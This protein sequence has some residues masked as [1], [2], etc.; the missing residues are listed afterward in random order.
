MK[1]Q[2]AVR[3]DS[4]VYHLIL[5]GWQCPSINR[6]F[7]SIT[8]KK[9]ENQRLCR[10]C[11]SAREWRKK[12][13]DWNQEE[14][15]SM[16]KGD[17]FETRYKH[18]SIFYP[19]IGGVDERLLK[20][21]AQYEAEKPKRFANILF[22]VEDDLNAKIRYRG[23]VKTYRVMLPLVDKEKYYTSKEW[24]EKR[25]KVFRRD[26]NRCVLCNSS[27]GLSAH[28]RSYRNFGNEPLEDLTTLCSR[29]HRRFHRI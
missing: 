8:D 29:C 6:H 22:V 13:K 9:P 26:G 20:W 4:E 17:L 24:A 3:E 12:F 19:G 23:S 27:E 7:C 1:I 21:L 25:K 10:R 28:H 2:Y 5:P 18:V 14:V 11:A 16:R 15:A